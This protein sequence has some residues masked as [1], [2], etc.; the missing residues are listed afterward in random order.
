[1]QFDRVLSYRK[2]D[3]EEFDNRDHLNYRKYMCSF[4]ETWAP[5]SWKQVLQKRLSYK[6]PHLVNAVDTRSDFCHSL[7][8]MAAMFRV[9]RHEFVVREPREIYDRTSHTFVVDE[10]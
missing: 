8:L 9:G 1:M 2:S 3:L 7:F 10:A 6:K 5:N 4:Y